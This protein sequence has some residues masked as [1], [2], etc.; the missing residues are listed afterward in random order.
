MSSSKDENRRRHDRHRVVFPI[1]VSSTPK[2]GRIGMCRNGSASGML[3]GTPSRFDIGDEL[4]L[5]FS[6]RAGSPENLVTAKIVRIGKEAA[7]RDHWCHRLVAVEFA[8]PQPTLERVFADL[9]PR[10]AHLFS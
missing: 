2:E 8:S 4:T 3:L 10:Q 7:N 6:V 1:K 5:R 9:A